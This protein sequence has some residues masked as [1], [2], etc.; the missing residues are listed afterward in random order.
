MFY[1]SY[2]RDEN[3]HD[4]YV[5]RFMEQTAIL[6]RRVLV[7]SVGIDPRCSVG[8]SAVTAEQLS[9]LGFFVDPVVARQQLYLT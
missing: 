4:L 1:I 5:V 8:Y 2:F 7:A 6:N 3:F 9:S